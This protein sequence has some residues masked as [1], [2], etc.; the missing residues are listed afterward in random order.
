MLVVA[1]RRRFFWTSACE[2]RKNKISLSSMIPSARPTFPPVAIIIFHLK[3]FV[4]VLRH[5]ETHVKIMIT[6]LPAG[7]LGRPSGSI[8]SAATAR[9]VN[10]KK[11]LNLLLK[12]QLLLLLA[13]RYHPAFK[14]KKKKKQGCKKDGKLGKWSTQPSPQ[15]WTLLWFEIWGFFCFAKFWKV[16]DGHLQKQ[17]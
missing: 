17:W 1:L 16:T 13:C 11:L 7:T 10:E 14:G 8:I 9:D 4:F 12:Q 3:L 5:F 2:W 15:Y 6:V